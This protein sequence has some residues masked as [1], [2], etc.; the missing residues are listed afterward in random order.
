MLASNDGTA[1]G[2]I[3]AL[4]EEGLAGRIL[5]TGQDADLTACQRIAQ[6]TQTMT[7]YKP[8][9]NLAARA[10]EAAVRLARRRP[11]I[12]SAGIDNG[13]VEVPS[14]LLDIIAV[15]K[16]NLRDTVVA[17]GFRSEQDVFGG[18]GK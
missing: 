6:G 8:I 15:T 7:V 17:D 4:S 3:Q 16:E 5:V 14:I 1:G 13:Q 11:V 18:G 2:A 9:K 10:A 12:A